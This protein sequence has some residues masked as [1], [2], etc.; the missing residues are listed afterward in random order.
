MIGK[1]NARSKVGSSVDKDMLSGAKPPAYRQPGNPKL[2]MASPINYPKGR[3]LS[4][5]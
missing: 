2:G 5:N 4:L 1:P 3:M